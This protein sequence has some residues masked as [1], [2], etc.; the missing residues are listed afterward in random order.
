VKR[1]GAIRW[2]D[3]ALHTLPAMGVAVACGFTTAFGLRSADWDVGVFIIPA[4]LVAALW[5]S[6]A[7][8]FLGVFT[9]LWP[10]REQRQHGGLIPSRQ[11]RWEA[12]A[13]LAAIPLYVASVYGFWKLQI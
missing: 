13:P 2:A 3:V 9:G 6:P 1:A 11:S 10:R 4:W 7:V 8:L 5:I 12:F